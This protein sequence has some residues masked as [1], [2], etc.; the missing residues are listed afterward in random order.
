MKKLNK[1]SMPMEGSAK[2][3]SLTKNKNFF[4]ALRCFIGIGIHDILNE[5]CIM[6]MRKTEAQ[7][8]E[9]SANSPLILEPHGLHV[10]LMGLESPLDPSVKS[11]YAT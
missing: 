4:I 7:R 10:K 5:N 3:T 2:F 1:R 11:E 6:M 8:L 9:L